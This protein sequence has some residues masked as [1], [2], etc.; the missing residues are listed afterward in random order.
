[1]I[2]MKRRFVK[3]PLEIEAFILGKDTRPEWAEQDHIKYY[4]GFAVIKTLEGEMLAEEGDYII[5]GFKGEIY[6]CKADIFEASY[7][8]VNAPFMAKSD[9]LFDA[10]GFRTQGNLIPAIELSDPRKQIIEYTDCAQQFL[11]IAVDLIN[12]NQPKE[13]KMQLEI[14]L[15]KINGIRNLAL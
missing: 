1:M 13:A 6:P 10:T 7:Q 8:E 9:A 14:C 15:D 11:K 4:I 5:K 12:L 3:K 2:E